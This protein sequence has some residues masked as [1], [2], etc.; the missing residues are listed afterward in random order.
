MFTVYKI[1]T[2]LCSL[3]YA[4]QFILDEN[5]HYFVAPLQVPKSGKVNNGSYTIFEIAQQELNAE[6]NISGHA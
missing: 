3:K 5:S 6:D 4:S 1:C 2:L